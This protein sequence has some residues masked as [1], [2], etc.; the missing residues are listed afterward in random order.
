MRRVADRQASGHDAS[1]ASV[2]VVRAQ[3]ASLEPITADE[4]SADV[5]RLELPEH[6]GPGLAERVRAGVAPTR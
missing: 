1:D 2:E 4:L 3:L 5:R 6:A